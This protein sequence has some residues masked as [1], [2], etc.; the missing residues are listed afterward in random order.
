V[1]IEVRAI[2]AEVREPERL[3]AFRETLAYEP[4]HFPESSPPEA[5]S[6]QRFLQKSGAFFGFHAVSLILLRLRRAFTDLCHRRQSAARA[7]AGC[8][9]EEPDVGQ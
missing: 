7:R 6:R 5:E 1:R 9:I 2:R 3:E 8:G 4:P